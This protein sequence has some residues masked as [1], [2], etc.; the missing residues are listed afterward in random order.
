MMNIS[1]EDLVAVKARLE[2]ILVRHLGLSS[3]FD[4]RTLLQTMVDQFAGQLELM[5]HL[6]NLPAVD[7]DNI[8]DVANKTHT[9]LRIMLTLYT[10]RCKTVAM[11]NHK[12]G[13]EVPCNQ[14][15]EFH[16]ALVGTNKVQALG[17]NFV[18]R[19]M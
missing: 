16:F 17:Y 11:S 9:Q 8:L 1:S 19:V 3:C 13:H 2:V 4:W 5:H 15:W 6:L 14:L 10:V 12:P 18:P 7:P